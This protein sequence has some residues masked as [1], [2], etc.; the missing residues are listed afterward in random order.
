MTATGIDKVEDENQILITIT[1]SPT[2]N[3]LQ[4][5]DLTGRYTFGSSGDCYLI[6]A[7][8]VGPSVQ[9]LIQYNSNLVGTTANFSMSFD[10]N[11]I[12]SNP[13]INYQFS[14]TDSSGKG[15]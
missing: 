6:S 14:I 12:R 4:L 3:N 8:S 15:F 10:Q 1:T 2:I 5:M 13:I 7:T 11:I 9:L